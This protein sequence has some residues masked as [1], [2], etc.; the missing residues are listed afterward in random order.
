[1]ASIIRR[2]DRHIPLAMASR[3]AGLLARR[4][5]AI[6]SSITSMLRGLRRMRISNHGRPQ[7]VRRRVPVYNPDRDVAKEPFRMA[8]RGH[9]SGEERDERSRDD[10]GDREDADLGDLAVPGLESSTDLL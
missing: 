1:M 9:R 10:R 6:A 7:G 2:A 3:S 5:S 8:V 4:T